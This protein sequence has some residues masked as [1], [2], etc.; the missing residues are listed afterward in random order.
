VLN[1]VVSAAALAR[2]R[3]YLVLMLSFYKST[4]YQRASYDY[5]V[6]LTLI[7]YMHVGQVSEIPMF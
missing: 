7:F 6:I 5:S 4:G 2:D 3:R 1:T